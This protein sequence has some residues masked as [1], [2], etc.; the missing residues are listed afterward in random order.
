MSNGI[1]KTLKLLVY[2]QSIL[3]FSVFL[4]FHRNSTPTQGTRVLPTKP[5]KETILMEHMFAL[6]HPDDVF[7]TVRKILNTNRTLNI[8]CFFQTHR[9]DSSVVAY[10]GWNWYW[11]LQKQVLEEKYQE[12]AN[13]WSHRRLLQLIVEKEKPLVREGTERDHLQWSRHVAY[14]RCDMILNVLPLHFRLRGSVCVDGSRL[15]S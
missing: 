8:T 2:E 15:C 6:R 12:Q 5:L 11:L 1:F 3:W 10:L 13:D 4:I 9:F 7:V 14:S